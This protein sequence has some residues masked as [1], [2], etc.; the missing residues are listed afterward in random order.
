MI[1][2]RNT[3][4][5]NLELFFS[6]GLLIFVIGVISTPKREKKS[7]WNYHQGQFTREDR[8]RNQ[9]ELGQSHRQLGIICMGTEDLL[10]NKY[11]DNRKLIIP[12][13][14]S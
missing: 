4:F 11:E 6:L 12:V 1:V 10:R 13:I 7:R 3:F 2:L 9:S 14:Q 5:N 8:Q